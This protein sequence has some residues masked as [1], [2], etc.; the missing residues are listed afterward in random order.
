M[1]R[2]NLQNHYIYTLH[3]FLVLVVTLMDSRLNEA[4]RSLNAKQT[5]SE[6]AE[7]FACKASN[8]VH[9][10]VANPALGMFFVQQHVRKSIPTFIQGEKKMTAEKEEIDLA[11]LE[12]QECVEIVQE[13]SSL[14]NFQT[15]LSHLKR[16]NQGF[17]EL[18]SRN[19]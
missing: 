15:M 6:H 7:N 13:M 18:P 19:R 9:Q 14:S 10:L 3:K 17:S 11:R 2:T 5:S 12:T 8:T 4:S 16:L 1:T